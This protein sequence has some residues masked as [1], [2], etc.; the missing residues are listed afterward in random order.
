MKLPGKW[1]RTKNGVR[2][3][4]TTTRRAQPEVVNVR[5]VPTVVRPAGTF[6]R[7]RFVDHGEPVLGTKLWTLDELEE[8]GVTWHDTRPAKSRRK[9]A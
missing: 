5:G 7:L 1:V 4:V 3:Q 8:A 2:A 9:R 6:I